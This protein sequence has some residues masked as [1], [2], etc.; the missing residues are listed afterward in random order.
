M[1][2]FPVKFTV[3]RPTV[4]PESL[5]IGGQARNRLRR[6]LA[7]MRAL[8][9]TEPAFVP[10][11]EPQMSRHFDSIESATEFKN[12]LVSMFTDEGLAQEFIDSAE[13]AVIETI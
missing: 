8:G 3:V 6:K 11:E 4:F 10:P 7:E 1:P 9:K 2:A 13:N 5:Q 12:F